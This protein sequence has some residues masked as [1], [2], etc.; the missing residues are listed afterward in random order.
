[1]STLVIGDV[2]GCLT[3]LDELLDVSSR[4]SPSRIVFLGDLVDRG[5]DGPGVVRRV[6]ELGAA[7]VKGNHEEKHVRYRKH[8]KVRAA[9]GK[10]NPMRPF[11]GAKLEAHQALTDD[12]IA[13]MD[14]LP[15]S[16]DLGNGWFA[17]HAGL[18]PSKTFEAQ[19]NSPAL[20]RTRYVRP[21]GRAMSL[22]EGKF[23]PAEPASF[24]SERWFGPEKIVYGHNVNDLISPRRDLFAVGIDTGCCFG[25]R[26]TGMVLAADGTYFF[27]HARAGRVY[28]DRPVNGGS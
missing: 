1:M 22:P 25:G 3:E 27:E 8:E 18:E 26:L 16:L 13:W 6:R 2:H 12:D 23:E 11:T 9:T 19:R 17:V 15:L 10:K 14:S 28:C 5:P 21:D 7:M 4:H 24:W 20:L